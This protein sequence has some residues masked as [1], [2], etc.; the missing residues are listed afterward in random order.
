MTDGQRIIGHLEWSTMRRLLILTLG[1][2]L[3]VAIFAGAAVADEH[4]KLTGLERAAQ[5]TMQGLEKSQGKAAEAPG[6]VN[7][8]KG[9]EKQGDKLTGRE[10]AAAAI[11]AAIERGNGRGNAFGRGH[12]AQVLR[13]L[14]GE[15]PGELNTSNHGQTVR[16]MV[17]AFNALRKADENG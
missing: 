10:R 7:R 9:L 8:A 5:A 13:I 3:F 14:L 4:A 2:A 16:E 6:Q 12:A 15:L 11:A 1:A 17:H